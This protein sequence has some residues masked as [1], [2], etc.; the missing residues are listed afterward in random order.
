MTTGAQKHGSTK[1]MRE[2]QKFEHDR[3]ELTRD[4]KDW[5]QQ[6]DD[7]L[8]DLWLAGTG[9]KS[10]ANQLNRPMETV[11]NR[12]WKLATGYRTCKKYKPQSRVDRTGK[13]I[14]KRDLQI[15][16]QW[17]RSGM[18]VE[19]LSNILGRDAN[20]VLAKVSRPTRRGFFND[21][22]QRSQSTEAGKSS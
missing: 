19:H 15:V 14:T 2:K 5:T 1:L 16:E 22:D 6:D 13:P 11:D 18:S 10:L 9:L 20:V 12:A 7:I 4:G 21:G 8:L 17:R 3:G